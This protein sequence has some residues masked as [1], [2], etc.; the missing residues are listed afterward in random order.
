MEQVLALLAA[1]NKGSL[2]VPSGLLTAKTTYT[3]N[4]RSYESIL[5]GSPDDPLIR[6]LSR[7]AAGYRNAA[8]ALH[9]ALQEPRA[10]IVSSDPPQ[11]AGDGVVVMLL[12]LQ[13]RL[14]GVQE[15]FDGTCTLRLR[16]SGDHL[17]AVEAVCAEEDLVRIAQARTF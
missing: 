12:L 4:G 1:F 3:L 13:G 16:F 14:R 10:T 2:D 7:G 17:A 9:Y 15:P 6:L 8:K 11:A 5:G